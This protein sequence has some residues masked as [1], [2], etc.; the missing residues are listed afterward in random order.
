MTINYIMICWIKENTLLFEGL[1]I[2]FHK[3]TVGCKWR[4]Y[5]YHM[6]L[7]ITD[8][9]CWLTCTG[10]DA[11]IPA[12]GGNIYLEDWHICKSVLNHILEKGLTVIKLKLQSLDYQQWLLEFSR[13][14]NELTSLL[15]SGQLARLHF[16]S[17]GQILLIPPDSSDLFVSDMFISGESVK[18]KMQFPTC[19]WW[20]SWL[21]RT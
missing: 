4:L 8:C 16:S 14:L 19:L 3:N 20:C 12:W 17:Q 13:K 11:D 9:C 1:N 18:W 21:S 15:A 10:I 2:N 5:M 7:R 6:Y